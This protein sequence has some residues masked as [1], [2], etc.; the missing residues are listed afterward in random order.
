[1]KKILLVAPV[2]KDNAINGGY[3]KIANNL[4]YIFKLKKHEY[5]YNYTSCHV[6]EFE[7]IDEEFDIVLF[8]CHPNMFLF[9]KKFLSIYKSKKDLFKKTYLHI[10]WET[11]PFPNYWKVLNNFFDGYATTSD[12]CKTEMESLTQKNCYKIPFYIEDSFYSL[13]KGR[14]SLTDKKEE[15]QFTV[16]F[17]G[18][19]T[20]RKGI[21]DA[22]TA[23][24]IFS[25][26]KEDDV[27][28]IC[29]YH[30]LSDKEIPVPV[31]AKNIIET[32]SYTLNRKP[33]IFLL[34]Y[35]ID[36]KTIIQLYKDSSLLLQCSRG[37]GFGLC[38][39]ESNLVGIP[40]TYTNFS[41]T[42]EVGEYCKSINA[43]IDCDLVPSYG[44][45]QYHYKINSNYGLPKLN[46]I[47]YNLEMYYGAWKANKMKYY[48]DAL[49]GTEK[50][51]EYLNGMKNEFLEG[52][53]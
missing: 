42:K 9:D 33:N 1:M 50:L 11:S 37:E 44:M 2:G 18:Q 38:G 43:P 14:L 20:K 3:N 19:N 49:K 7:N 41:S 22:L 16:L 35:D 26:G 17:M 48:E 24:S 36:D 30:N 51:P 15:K 23:F 6:S 31:L 39:L 32:N 53:L 5:N 8:Q 25:N 34:D 21:E 28:M 13:Y 47:L 52:V 10:A 40:H 29:K 12:F 4:D 46:S 27:R 45:S